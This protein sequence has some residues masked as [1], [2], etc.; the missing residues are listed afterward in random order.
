MVPSV[1]STA[2][3]P[4]FFSNTT[5]DTSGDAAASANELSLVL[6]RCQVSIALILDITCSPMYIVSTTELEA[7]I[8]PWGI[9][10]NS[11]CGVLPFIDWIQSAR[12]IDYPLQM[13]GL[14]QEALSLVELAMQIEQS[15][16]DPHNS[17]LF[18]LDAIYDILGAEEI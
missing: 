17:H 1:L 11:S 13:P 14:K 4:H 9:V 16:V 6:D 8:R 3:R 7:A 18:F 12:G 15:P 5:E 2:Q 10:S